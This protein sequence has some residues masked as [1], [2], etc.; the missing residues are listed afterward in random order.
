MLAA[1]ADA[2][3]SLLYPPRC[4]VCRTLG[5]QSVLCGPC[6]SQIAP[7]NA[8]C[9]FCGHADGELH[10]RRCRTYP[11]AFDGTFALG[12]Y[13]GVLKAAV[14]RFKYRDRP[15]LAEPLGILLAH[16]ARPTIDREWVDI[17]ALLP[18]PMHPARQRVRGYN[19]SARLARVLSRELRLSMETNLLTRPRPTKAQVGLTGDSRRA[20]LS[21][22]FG[23]PRPD[24]VQGRCLLLIDD[25]STTGATLSECASALKQSGADAVYCLVLAA[26]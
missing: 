19:Q 10:C 1:C 11:P 15:Q 14:H 5:T 17:D 20:N 12:T 7:I 4:A 23:V 16:R 6:A 22:A 2:F 21:G 26:G 9:P 25:V 18:V 24:A 3:L 13:D 8:P